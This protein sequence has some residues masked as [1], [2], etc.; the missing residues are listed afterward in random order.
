MF[1][2][3]MSAV[4]IAALALT[5]ATAS[6]NHG[7]A[8]QSFAFAQP[9]CFVQAAVVAQPVV[10]QQQIAYAAPVVQ[11]TVLAAP[12][13]V[14]TFAVA[15]A[16]PVQVLAVGCHGGCFVGQRIRS[17][18]AAPLVAVRNVAVLTKQRVLQ[19]GQPVRNLLR[20]IF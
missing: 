4:A 17:F 13:Q 16:A 3:L 7:I 2:R 18:A 6:A 14:Q 5:G 12:V 9:A 11:Q 1:S 20:R 10:V 15:H 19:Q 8:V